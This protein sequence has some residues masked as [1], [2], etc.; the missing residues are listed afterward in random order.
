MR[1]VRHRVGGWFT[2]TRRRDHCPNLPVPRL[3]RNDQESTVLWRRYD[4][5]LDK[6]HGNTSFRGINGTIASRRPVDPDAFPRYP[7]EI[8]RIS[9]IIHWRYTK[10]VFVYRNGRISLV[11]GGK[12]YLPRLSD[13][14]SSSGQGVPVLGPSLPSSLGLEN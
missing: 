8:S 1:E 12:G 3:R 6:L 11:S 14:P 9:R 13:G 4:G 2:D 5:R 10:G 7:R